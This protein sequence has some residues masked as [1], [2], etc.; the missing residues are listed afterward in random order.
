MIR[1]VLRFLCV[2]AA[3]GIVGCAKEEMPTDPSDEARTLSKEESEGLPKDGKVVFLVEDM[4]S[5][6]EWRDRLEAEKKKDPVLAAKSRTSE[7]AGGSGHVGTSPAAPS[8]DGTEPGLVVPA[9]APLPDEDSPMASQDSIEP[10]ILPAAPTSAA[11]LAILPAPESSRDRINQLVN[12]HDLVDVGGSAATVELL[13]RVDA[14]LSRF[15]Q[16]SF[17]DLRLNFETVGDPVGA[18]ALV[19][20]EPWVDQYFRS[21]A[22]WLPL[23]ADERY[24]DFSD[25]VRISEIAGGVITLAGETGTFNSWSMASALGEH[26]ARYQNATWGRDIMESLGYRLTPE[27]AASEYATFDRWYMIFLDL[28]ASRVPGNSYPTSL[29]ESPHGHA[30]DLI[31]YHLLKNDPAASVVRMNAGFVMPEDT[32]MLLS[33]KL[34]F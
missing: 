14:L 29:G 27:G 8:A 20:N 24:I 12:K 19:D 7:D 30:P 16:D 28:D 25:P 34:G 33:E 3:L 13:D 31:A 6:E 9:S 22:Y 5:M 26:V 11:P 4:G 18:P 15:P 2:S 32:G 21:S 10:A 1:R 23:S 17:R